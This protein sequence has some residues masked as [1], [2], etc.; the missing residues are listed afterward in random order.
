M[1][2]KNKQTT[3]KPKFRRG[4]CVVLKR[5]GLTKQIVKLV[6]R[7]ALLPELWWVC[8]DGFVHRVS[9]LRPPTKREKNRRWALQN[10]GKAV[11]RHREYR[12][13][14]KAAGLPVAND[15]DSFRAKRSAYMV[16]YRK[17]EEKI[18]TRARSSVRR[19]LVAGRLVRLP[20]VRC[21]ARA[22]AHHP[23]YHKPLDV[24]WLC[25][26]HHKEAHKESR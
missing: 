24:V 23:D 7:D 20:C 22:E 16:E 15:M 18:K 25:P 14:R 8:S 9:D 21:G 6:R 3:S 13:E 26:L 12:E 19:A 1:S 17:R 4:Q 10:P 5:R 2:G 11:S